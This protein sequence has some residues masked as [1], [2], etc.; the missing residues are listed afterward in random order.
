MNIGVETKNRTQIINGVNKEPFLV[1]MWSP[2]QI[3][4]SDIFTRDFLLNTE[5]E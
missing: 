5:N 2:L 1:R 4:A 3:N